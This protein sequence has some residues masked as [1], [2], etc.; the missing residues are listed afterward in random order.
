MVVGVAD[1]HVVLWYLYRN[2]RLSATARDSIRRAAAAG[3]RIGISSISLA[4]IVYLVEK[5][6]IPPDSYQDLVDAVNQPDGVFLEVPLDQRVTHSMARVKR[7]E[8]PD[9]PDRI[10]VATALS[11]RV[12]LLSRDG[13][14]RASGIETV[15]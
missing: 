7:E 14:I 10:I 5:S 11:L 12:P 9:L 8:V 4:E 6:R 2:P 15:W 3:H 13:R 1:T